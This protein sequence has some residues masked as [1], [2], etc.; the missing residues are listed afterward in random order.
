MVLPFVVRVEN[1]VVQKFFDDFNFGF[2]HFLFSVS[3]KFVLRALVVTFNFLDVFDGLNSEVFF[4][5]TALFY[6]LFGLLKIIETKMDAI[7]ELPRKVLAE[8]VFNFV[9]FGSWHWRIFFG[10]HF[11]W[12]LFG[13]T[14]LVVLRHVY[15][16][17][18]FPSFQDNILVNRVSFFGLVLVVLTLQLFE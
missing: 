14:L 12:S 7:Q 18:S 6:L 17:E 2:W 15:W 1:E 9:L 10:L 16:T 11:A 5:A 4:K 3:L 13:I 8:N